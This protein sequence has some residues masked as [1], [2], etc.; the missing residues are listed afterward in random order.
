MV[1]ATRAVS[2][3]EAVV[4]AAAA[5]DVSSVTSPIKRAV[6]VYPQI[7]LCCRTDGRTLDRATRRDEMR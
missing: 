7:L 3:V 5:V 4:A 1:V 2:S 6:A